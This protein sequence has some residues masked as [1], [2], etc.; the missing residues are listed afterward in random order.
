M[1]RRRAV[2]LFSADDRIGTSVAE[3]AKRNKRKRP[4]QPIR[5]AKKWVYQRFAANR[6]EP[7]TLLF[8]FGCQRSGT[9][10][11]TQLFQN[12]LRSKVYGER[13]FALDGGF[14]LQPFEEIKRIVQNE[15][16]TLL[17]GKPLVASQ[18]A[19]E[20]L[21]FFVSAK[22]I[23]M[24]RNYADVAHSSR[25]RFSRETAMRNLRFLVSDSAERTF[26][27]EKASAMTKE[28]VA[29]F[30]SEEMSGDDA[31]ILFWYVRNVLFFDQQLERHDRVRLCR[32]EDFVAA[33][34]KV[35]EDVYAFLGLEFP[36]PR[37][38]AEVHQRSVRKDVQL[39]ASEELLQLCGELQERLVQAVAAQR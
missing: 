3:L 18:D 10:M 21:D 4:R 24:F 20:I 2:P 39:D 22:S 1:V 15:R 6:A 13:G 19:I 25:R 14:E 31:Q 36:G 8:V 27:T 30:F 12:D 11:F 38:T 17:V 28:L 33:P 35:M 34:A 26:A 23:W 29:R 5:F 37:M 16:A 7:K 9:T 32:Y